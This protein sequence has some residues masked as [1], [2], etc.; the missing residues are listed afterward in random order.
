[1]ISIIYSNIKSLYILY[2][3]QT[4]DKFNIIIIILQLIIFKL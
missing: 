3:F 1:M 2:N 4:L